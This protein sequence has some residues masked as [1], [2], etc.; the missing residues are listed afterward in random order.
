VDLNSP[1]T[2]DLR[3]ISVAQAFQFIGRAAAPTGVELGATADGDV[4]V[5]G[6]LAR[7]K[8]PVS[9]AGM[10]PA[11][12]MAVPGV[13]VAVG[14]RQ[15][16]AAER[17][18]TRVYDVDKLTHRDPNELATL[19]NLVLTNLKLGKSSAMVAAQPFNGKLV[20]TATSDLQDQV[21][22][23]LK[24]LREAAP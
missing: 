24:M 23:L 2:L 1:V 18:V 3:G 20:V 8:A 14:P 21:Q 13:A 5:F 10:E 4:I 22:D 15:F 11:P 17:A 19:T 16:A 12:G 6:V 9:T 7:P